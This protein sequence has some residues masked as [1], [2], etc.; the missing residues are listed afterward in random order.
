[1]S[2]LTLNVEKETVE[3]GVHKEE[4]GKDGEDSRGSIILEEEQCD[5][6]DMGK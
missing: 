3:N 1:M 2:K 5:E 6:I 4:N